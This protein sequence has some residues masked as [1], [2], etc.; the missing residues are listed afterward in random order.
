MSLGIALCVPTQK[1]PS[2]KVQMMMNR[3]SKPVYNSLVG[4]DRDGYKLCPVCKKTCAEPEAVD[5][6]VDPWRLT[7]MG[8]ATNFEEFIDPLLRRE[9]ELNAWYQCD[10]GHHFVVRYPLGK[11]T[12]QVRSDKPPVNDQK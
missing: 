9:P 1:P 10:C 11:G 4:N 8:E 7:C 3:F 12:T 6:H 5:I 2:M